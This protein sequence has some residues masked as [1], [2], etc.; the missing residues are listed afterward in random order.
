MKSVEFFRPPW[1]L[2]VDSVRDPGLQSTRTADIHD[3]LSLFFTLFIQFLT[4]LITIPI[5]AHK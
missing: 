2:L 1:H 4:V 3:F 5:P